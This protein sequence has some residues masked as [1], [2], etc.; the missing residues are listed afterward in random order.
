MQNGVP[1]AELTRHDSASSLHSSVRPHR[2]HVRLVGFRTVAPILQ[3]GKAE[4]KNVTPGR[5]VR[6]DVQRSNR[7]AA[8]DKTKAPAAGVS[9]VIKL[10][11]FLVKKPELTREEFETYWLET[12]SPLAADLPGVKRYVTS[13]P[14]EPERSEFDGV[15]ELYFEDREA[16]SAAFDSEVGETVLT[17]AEEFLEVGAGPRMIVEESVQV[18]RT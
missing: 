15:L 3:R 16:L 10:V 2:S 6:L 13:L 18:D 5:R 17:D 1:A 4:H 14:T 9:D 12:H 7:S 8:I 11:E